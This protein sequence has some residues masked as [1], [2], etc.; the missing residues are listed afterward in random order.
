M[1]NYEYTFLVYAEFFVCITLF[2]LVINTILLKFAKTLGIRDKEN[3]MIRWTNVSK[4]ALG[5]ITFFM[6]FLVS[7]ACFGILFDHN[8][9]FKNGE[10]IS[11]IGALCLAFIMG[12]ADDAYNT[13]PWLKFFIQITCGLILIFGSLKTGNNNNIISIFEIDF[14]NYLITVLW[15]VGIMNSINMLDNMDGIT[16]VTSIFIFLT[17]LVFLALQN[18]FQYYDFMIVLGLI[19]ALV[20]FLFYNWSPSKMYMGDSGSQFLGLLLAFIG[21][22]YF[23]NSTIFETQELVP[24]KQIIIVCLI[25]ILPISDTTSVFINRIYR[26]QSPFI[27]GKD[28][29]THHLSFLGFNNSQIIF[30]FSG[31]AFLSSIIAIAL[32]RFVNIW[33]NFKFIMYV[34]YILAIFITLYISTQQHKDLRK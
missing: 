14:L 10:I 28:H 22:K 29:T 33:T 5:G 31:I 7:T 26:K 19:G 15:V 8:E 18:A 27:G 16:T 25:F 21:I 12:L 17:A 11:L 1:N 20:S 13:K 23:W 2:G 32:Y 30:I 24:S 3:T 9:L 4:P 6:S 34:I